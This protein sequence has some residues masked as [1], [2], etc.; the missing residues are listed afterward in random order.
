MNKRAV[1]SLATLEE[2]KHSFWEEPNT[3]IIVTKTEEHKHD[4]GETSTCSSYNLRKKRRLN[5]KN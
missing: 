5:Y 1:N 4:T 2:I 3:G